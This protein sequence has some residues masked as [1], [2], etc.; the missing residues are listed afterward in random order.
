MDVKNVVRTL[1]WA[2]DGWNAVCGKLLKWSRGRIGARWAWLNL[3]DRPSLRGESLGTC[4]M[5][6][7]PSRALRTKLAPEAEDSCR[8]STCNIR[9]L[10]ID[11]TA[12]TIYGFQSSTRE[13]RK[14][15]DLL[16]KHAR[17][18][19][20]HTKTPY[21]IA[22]DFN[23]DVKTLPSYRAL[24]AQGCGEAFEIAKKQTRKRPTPHL[25]RGNQKRHHDNPPLPDA[26][27]HPNRSQTRPGDRCTLTDA[28]HIREYH[29]AK[30]KTTTG[31]TDTHR[32]DPGGPEDL[33]QHLPDNQA[34]RTTHVP[35]TTRTPAQHTEVGKERGK[36]LGPGNK[37][38]PQT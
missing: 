9:I 6:R 20:A 19:T 5:A 16:L 17:E 8:I 38:L 14:R 29:R 10:G 28:G 37:T 32:Q 3:T 2:W 18:L 27:D 35:D 4:C 7:L 25:Q 30:P 23:E 15:N 26:V 31:H 33:G 13:R 36:I 34:R 1:F 12:I 24:N 22:G 11:T 21:I